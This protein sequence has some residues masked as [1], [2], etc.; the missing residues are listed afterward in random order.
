MTH[1]SQ[2]Q[3][4]TLALHLYIQPKASRN[5]IAGLHNDSVKLCITAP[6]V[7]NAANKAIVVFLAKLF[8]IPKSAITIQS[9]QQGRNKLVILSDI[10]L[11]EA[12]ARLT[13]AMEK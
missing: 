12:E 7:D 5:R 1:L 10:S 11:A 9:G 13:D 6:P 4:N 8:K 2:R 3:D